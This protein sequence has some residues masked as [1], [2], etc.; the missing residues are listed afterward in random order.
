MARPK[1]SK[2][3]HVTGMYEYKATIG[4]SFDGKAIR[5][6]FYSSKSLE[7]AK[8]KAFFC[9]DHIVTDMNALRAPADKLEMIVDKEMWPFPTYGDIIFEV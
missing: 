6:S 9:K 4:K 1:K 3:N 2:P 8:E 7:D 5:K